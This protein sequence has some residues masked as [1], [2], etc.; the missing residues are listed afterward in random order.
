[1]TN[2]SLND[3]S[4]GH[5]VAEWLAEQKDR[6]GWSI[7][8]LAEFIDEQIAIMQEPRADSLINKFQRL[9]DQGNGEERE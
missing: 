6:H 4:I 5:K 2:D 8:M 1:M 9:K 3:R 7:H